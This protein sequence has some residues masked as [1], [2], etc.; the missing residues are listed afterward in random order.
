MARE[1]QTLLFT[2]LVGSTDRLRQLGDAGWSALLDR[3]HSAVRAVLAAHEGREVDTAGDG[4]LACFDSP[5]AAVRAAAR[6]VERVGALDLE[7]RAGLHT[8]EVEVD[9]RGLRGVGVHLAAR[10]MAEAGPG[11]V[12]VSSTLRD[13]VAGSGMVFA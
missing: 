11:E 12:L 1:V 13:L 6:V 3:H 4:F 2:D 7:V 8:G 5:T 10:V 9:G